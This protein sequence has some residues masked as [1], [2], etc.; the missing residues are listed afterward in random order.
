MPRTGMED[1]GDGGHGGDSQGWAMTV[2]WALHPAVFLQP[3]WAWCFL[4]LTLGHPALAVW[5]ELSLYLAH[6]SFPLSVGLMT[7]PP[8]SQS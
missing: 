4:S 1:W 2:P 8:E 7:E 3:L 6:I 5:A